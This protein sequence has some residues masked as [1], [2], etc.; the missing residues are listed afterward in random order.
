[1]ATTTKRAIG[2]VRVSRVNGREGNRFLSPEIQRERIRQSCERHGLKLVATH[3]E[4]DISG[5]KPLEERPEL[6]RALADVEA[7]KADAIVFSY[8]DRMDRSIATSGELCR[9]MDTAGGT[10]IADGNIVTHASHDGWR[11]TTFESFLTE[12]QRRAV[13]EKMRDVQRRCIAEGKPPWARVP[14]GYQREDD[15]TFAVHERRAKLVL[16]AFEMRAEGR[17]IREVRAMLKRHGVTL[18]VR[19]GEVM[20]GSRAYLGELHFGELVNLQA[21]PAIVPRELWEQ[22]Q[23]TRIPRGPMPRSELLLA[24]LGVLRCGSCGC[25]MSATTLPRK[26]GPY[27]VYRCGQNNDCELHVVISATL[28]EAAVIAEVQRWLADPETGSAASGVPD[29]HARLEQA[30]DALDGAVRSLA[31]A[32]LGSEP[33]TV[34]TLAQLHDARDRA[35]ERYDDALAVDGTLTVKLSARDWDGLTRDGQRELIKALGMRVRI[36]PG[37]GRG[38][39]KI[40]WP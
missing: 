12:D 6:S 27:G 32:G 11:R 28:V 30:Q 1:M 18:S 15:G 22:V 8:R 16:R 36:L 25:R 33:A 31:A 19:G 35:K 37:R 34:E 13:K 24:R 4:L 39:I 23:K 3:E 2:I 9:R 7:G 21:W 14:V 40:D 17:T 10:L 38:R 29:A 5:G 26:T 20:L